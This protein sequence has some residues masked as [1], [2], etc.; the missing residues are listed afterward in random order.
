MQLLKDNVEAPT[1]LVD[2]EGVGLSAIRVDAASLR[3]EAMARMSDVAAHPEVRA[4]WPVIAQ[5]LEASA[6]PQVRNMAR[7]AAICCSVRAAAI[8]VT[9]V[10]HAT[11]ASRPPVVRP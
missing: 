10:S 1:E 6:S 7:S 5:A 9:L 2:L 11:S 3:L 8:S 4:R